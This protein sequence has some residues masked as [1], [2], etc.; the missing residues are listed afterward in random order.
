M[1]TQKPAASLAFLSVVVPKPQESHFQAYPFN[2]KGELHR[3]AHAEASPAA[4]RVTIDQ[5]RPSCSRHELQTKPWRLWMCSSGPAEVGARGGS[6]CAVGRET[7]AGVPGRPTRAS[8]ASRP[9]RQRRR[10]RL[11]EQCRPKRQNL[12]DFASR[13]SWR[14]L[15]SRDPSAKDHHWQ[16]NRPEAAAHTSAVASDLVCEHT[17]FR[18]SQV[19]DR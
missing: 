18:V 19:G 4:L 3:H 8:C 1:R 10:A 13:R 12:K 11:H 9:L 2:S 7:G 16:R 5:R 6:V 15:Q 14:L 17:T